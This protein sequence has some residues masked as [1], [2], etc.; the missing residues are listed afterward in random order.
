MFGK[1][2]EKHFIGQGFEMNRSMI[3]TLDLGWD[4]L[5]VL[6]KEELNRVDEKLVKQY[7]N[8]ARAVERFHIVS[9][10]MISALKGM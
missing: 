1:L 9:K 10:P 3:D 2:F 6:P 4:L 7:Y 5:S 8:H